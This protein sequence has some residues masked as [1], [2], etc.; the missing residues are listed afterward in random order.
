M[1]RYTITIEPGMLTSAEEYARLP[2]EPGWHTELTDGRV[3]R[4]PQVK[5]HAHGWIIDNLSR[6]L[7]PYVHDHE[8]GRLT[9]SQEGYDISRPGAE[10]ETVWAPDLAFV[11]AEHLPI[12]REARRRGKYAPLAPDLAV[13]VVSPSEGRT[14]VTEKVQR[15]LSAGTRLLWVIWPQ[16]QTVEVWQADEPMQSLR[17]SD[18]LD[19]LEVVS[20]F[21][22]PVAE[23]FEF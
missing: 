14:Y 9:Y 4:M 20:G 23:L 18:Q 1:G 12:V 7:S 10:G 19:G 3:V 5:D 8:L 16:S 11:S 15:W 13:E 22:M 2:D 21:T 17:A 6:R